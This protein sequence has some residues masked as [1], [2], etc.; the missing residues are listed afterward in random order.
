M[1]ITKEDINVASYAAH[2]FGIADKDITY[3]ED[4]TI[5]EIDD[6]VNKITD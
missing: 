6:I 1:N 4:W 5:N 3:V 2:G